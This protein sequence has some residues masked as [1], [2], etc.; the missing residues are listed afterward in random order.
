MLMHSLVLVALLSCFPQ[1]MVVLQDPRMRH[2]QPSCRLFHR[3]VHCTSNF[4]ERDVLSV[5]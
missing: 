2:A 5:I 4:L 1:G 3:D